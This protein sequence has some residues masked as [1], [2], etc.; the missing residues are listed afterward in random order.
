M[1]D[2]SSYDFLPHR[3][4]AA[5]A[6]IWDRFLG[7]RAAALD[8]PP[9]RPPNRPKA[10]AWGFLAGSG[11]SGSYLGACPVDSSMTWY[12]STLGSLERFFERSGMVLSVWQNR[13]RCQEGGI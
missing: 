13:G 7:V 5:F 9:L 2:A 6:A 8:I 10:T 12:A 1:P 11:A 4:F 3:A